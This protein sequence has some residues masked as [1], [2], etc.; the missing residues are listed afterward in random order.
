MCARVS[1]TS[2]LRRTYMSPRLCMPTSALPVVGFRFGGGIRLRLVAFAGG[3]RDVGVGGFGCR[4]LQV[5]CG[6]AGLHT[7]GYGSTY[8]CIH[9]QPTS[10]YINLQ[11]TCT[12]VCMYRYRYMGS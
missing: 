6:V 4:R 8:V 7:Y 9:D 12:Y 3:I 11:Y 10:T 2:L 1:V 5:L